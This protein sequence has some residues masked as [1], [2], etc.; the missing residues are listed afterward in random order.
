VFA[1]AERV[2]ACARGGR[3]GEKARHAIDSSGSGRFASLSAHA[4]RRH[5][6]PPARFGT[7]APAFRAWRCEAA[8]HLIGRAVR[9]TRRAN[10]APRCKD[11]LLRPVGRG[12]RWFPPV[13]VRP[14]HATSIGRRSSIGKLLH[15]LC[16]LRHV[17]L[18]ASA[19]SSAR[20]A[21]TTCTRLIR[22]RGL[23]DSHPIGCCSGWGQ[24]E[25]AAK[26]LAF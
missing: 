13:P 19:P 14:N 20:P 25:A 4:H 26:A 5:D 7:I 8:N 24:G 6:T 1:L 17:P 3:G 23:Q 10:Q 2:P 11:E 9:R 18:G 16:C 15:L 12:R 22:A 21:A